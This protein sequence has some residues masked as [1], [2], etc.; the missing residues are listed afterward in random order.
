RAAGRHLGRAAAIIRV[1]KRRGRHLLAEAPERF[2]REPLDADDRRRLAGEGRAFCLGVEPVAD[3][4]ERAVAGLLPEGAADR[5][6]AAERCE[7]A[8]QEYVAPGTANLLLDRVRDRVRRRR[9]LGARLAVAAAADA[10]ELLVIDQ[11][12][13]HTAHRI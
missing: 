4:D 11:L 6:V 3:L 7:I 1:L 13:Q 12:A 9:R 5:V 2:G 8:A 10:H